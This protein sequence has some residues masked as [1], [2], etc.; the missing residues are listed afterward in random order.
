MADKIP[1]TDLEGVWKGPDE[2]PESKDGKG[3][4]DTIHVTSADGADTLTYEG[5]FKD[6]TCDV[7]NGGI[8]FN[9][10]TGNFRLTRIVN[11][12]SDLDGI[13]VTE[14]GQL[15]KDWVKKRVVEKETENEKALTWKVDLYVKHAKSWGMQQR[16]RYV[17]EGK[18]IPGKVIVTGPKG[19][20]GEVEEGSDAKVEVVDTGTAAEKY[21]IDIKREKV[22]YDIP[23]MGG[24]F[25]ADWAAGY[26]PPEGMACADHLIKE[27]NSFGLEAGALS[28]F[29][30]FYAAIFEGFTTGLGLTGAAAAE[31]FLGKLAEKIATGAMKDALKG[32][33][34]AKTLASSLAKAL[35][36]KMSKGMPGP[37]KEIASKLA[38]KAGEATE[39][40]AEELMKLEQYM[41][42]QCRFK[43]KTFSPGTLQARN[44]AFISALVDTYEG[45]AHLIVFS[46]VHKTSAGEQ[47]PYVVISGELGGLPEESRAPHFNVPLTAWCRVEAFGSK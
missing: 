46:P 34:G 1:I 5:K 3:R 8:P 25:N 4:T 9:P 44:I 42:T 17:M 2:T 40:K 26:Q 20:D 37:L 16:C 14:T 43:V 32:E 13:R 10:E 21:A 35:M 23:P 6:W 22:I 36:S 47:C 7:A 39:L 28:D 31:T 27:L 11:N 29:G 12:V 24:W 18:L 19:A 15:L 33:L 38:G 41:K 45:T 30:Q